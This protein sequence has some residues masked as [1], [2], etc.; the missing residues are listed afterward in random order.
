M[1]VEQFKDDVG[2]GRIAVNR[3]VELVVTMQRELQ[4][5]SRNSNRQ[6]GRL[7]NWSGNWTDRR[8]KRFRSRF[9]CGQKNSGRSARGKKR[10]KRQRR[11]RGGRITTAEKIARAVR[12]ERVF[13]AGAAGRTLPTV[14]HA[15][16]MAAG[17]R[18]SRTRRV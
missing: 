12:T 9:R 4:G 7:R 11:S 16:G 18:Q 13:P 17:E 6:G 14:A 10:R 2:E 1:D 8:N 5:R 3:L 15:A